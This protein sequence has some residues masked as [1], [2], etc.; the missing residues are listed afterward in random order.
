MTA[1]VTRF[2]EA[3]RMTTETKVPTD[4]QAS[5]A[6]PHGWTPLL[7]AGGFGFLLG[8]FVTLW[9]GRATD[10][11]NAEIVLGPDA[12][13]LIATMTARREVDVP[14]ARWA[15]SHLSSD[16]SGYSV[17]YSIAAAHHNALIEFL[18]V[19]ADTGGD[20][21]TMVELV[22]F[23]EKADDSHDAF[24]KWIE[25]QRPKTDWSVP[26]AATAYKVVEE[27]ASGAGETVINELLDTSNRR[28]ARTQ[29]ITDSLRKCR[30]PSWQDL[31]SAPSYC[32]A[33][34]PPS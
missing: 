5:L 30:W 13:G 10:P 34:L 3:T 24:L 22:A 26:A 23:A 17:E 19:L 7:K 16:I 6:Q 8:I 18:I 28:S 20:A 4:K 1:A 12:P 15:R 31:D 27:F 25:K 9:W 2:S 33:V 21:D 11:E 32:P 29:R 14:L